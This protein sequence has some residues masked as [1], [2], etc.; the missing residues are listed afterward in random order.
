[1]ATKNNKAPTSGLI[2]PAVLVCSC[3]TLI[4][5]LRTHHDLHF[6]VGIVESETSNNHRTW[7]GTISVVAEANQ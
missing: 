4:G 1:M 5:T 6:A 7:L 3:A 2:D